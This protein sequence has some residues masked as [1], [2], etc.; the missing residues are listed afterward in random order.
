M[1]LRFT[2]LR[3]CWLFWLLAVM[4]GRGTAAGNDMWVYVTQFHNG[5]QDWSWVPHTSTNVVS[6]AGTNAL[7]VSPSSGWQALYFEHD[8]MLDVGLYTNVT[9]WVNGGPTGGQ[10]VSVNGLLTTGQMAGQS[11]GINGKLPT[12]AWL[13]VVVSL[14]SL[15][16][17]G[18]TNFNGLEIW[19][20]SGNVQSNFLVAGVML[21]AAPTPATVHVGL[22]A[23][24]TVRSVAT[25]LFGINQVAWDGNVDTPTTVNVMNDIASPCL[26][27]PGGSWGDSYHWTNEYRGWGSYSTNFIHLATNTHAQA[28]IIVNYGSSTPQEAAYGVRLFNVTN[29][30]GFNYWEVG[31]EVFGSWEEDDNTNA[32]WLPHDPWTYAE[33]FTNYYAQMKAVDP[34]IRIGAMVL[35]D[36]T[37]GSNYATHFAVNPRTGTTN[38]GWTPVMLA[39]FKSLGVSP[40]FVVEHKYAPSDGDTYNLLWSSTWA[41]DAAAIRQMLTDYLGPTSSNITIECT[42]N[43]CGGDRQ[44][45]SLVG[46]LFYADSVAQAMPTEIRSRLWWDTRNGQADITGSDP[47]YYGWRTNADGAYT[48]DGGIIYNLGTPTNRYPEY[49]TAKLLTLFA[50]GGDTLVTVTNDCPWL[51]TYGV[52]RANGT[53]A[54]L[55]INKNAVSNLTTTVSLAGYQPVTNAM[56]YSYGIPQDT[57]AETGVGSMDVQ[58]NSIVVTGRVWT[59]T[60]A[61][62]SASVIVFSPVPSLG[63]PKVVAGKLVFQLQGQVGASYVF[64]STSNLMAS[65]TSY[66]TSSLAS[67]QVNYTNALTN[68][69]RFWR[70]HTLP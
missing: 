15:G 41:S 20:S 26:R 8:P 28:F 12:N 59:N 62:Y 29:H 21:A 55:T 39:T 18:Q 34:T 35:T 52:L 17:A 49:Y 48:S 56:L 45:V 24:R 46:G 32:P 7:L 36:E 2:G 11:V 37:S 23:N 70:V 5:W 64:Q 51:G 1:N 43:G 6:P 10:S 54:L 61:P 44:R 69:S 27:W 53:L 33:R 9:F 42:E 67:A 4:P 68:S 14:A 31:N 38:Y 47:A 60:F 65:W 19:S 66:A 22:L 13:Q 58:T 3:L 50:A 30:C 16:V 25:N 63:Q 57:A 40:D